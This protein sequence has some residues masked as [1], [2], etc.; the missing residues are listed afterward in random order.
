MWVC[1]FACFAALQGNHLE[2]ELSV[3]FGILVEKYTSKVTL[4]PGKSV[5]VSANEQESKAAIEATNG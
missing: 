1:L 2:A 3:G 5:V 4:E